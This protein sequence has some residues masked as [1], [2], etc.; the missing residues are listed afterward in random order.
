MHSLSGLFPP[1]LSLPVPPRLA[2][3]QDRIKQ[4][5]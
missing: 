5:V 2:G 1:L 4:R 3:T